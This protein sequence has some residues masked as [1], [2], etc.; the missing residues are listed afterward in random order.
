MNVGLTKEFTVAET[1]E[2][3]FHMNPLGS[4][5]PY[6]FR[7][8]FYQNHL[9]I[10]GPGVSA[11]VLEVLNKGKWSDSLN[12]TYITLIPKSKSPLKGFFKL[13][14]D[15]ALSKVHYKVGISV[16]IRD[17][18]GKIRATLR[19]K[20]DLFLNPFLAEVVAV[21][22]LHATLFC[23]DVGFKYIILEGDALQGVQGIQNSAE[24]GT[25]TCMIMADTRSM[26]ANFDSWSVQHIERN[27][28]KAAHALG[29]EALDILN[30]II[31][32]EKILQCI[33]SLL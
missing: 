2:V 30:T 6:G 33:L 15:A 16:I 19:M 14:L 22:A 26:L 10:V 20:R 32:M 28:N 24:V 27:K 18:E 3:I 9:E 13:N 31:V 17:W 11:V 7:A 23:Q 12:D 21:A 29:K 8:S 4:L 5:G 1:K 25:S